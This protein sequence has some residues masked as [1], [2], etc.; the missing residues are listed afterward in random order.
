LTFGFD[1]YGEGTMTI[2]DLLNAGDRFA[3]VGV[4]HRGL[5]RL[6]VG[7]RQR[8]SDIIQGFGQPFRSRDQRLLVDFLHDSESVIGPTG[9]RLLI[10]GSQDTDYCEKP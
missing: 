3:R 5:E 2:E 1:G 7:R 10:P 6:A 8:R 9:N 4:L